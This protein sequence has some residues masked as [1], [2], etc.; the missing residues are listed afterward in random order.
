MPILVPGTIVQGRYRVVRPAGRGGMGTVYEALDT[1][2]GCSVALKLMT[3]E[4]AHLSAAFEHE[5]RLLA[6]LRHPV[7]P[8]VSDH[9]QDE[10]AQFLVMQ[11]IPGEDLGSAL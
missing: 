11:F 10:G 2:L 7:L 8:V 1:R 3:G 6:S 4:G 9:F 5:A